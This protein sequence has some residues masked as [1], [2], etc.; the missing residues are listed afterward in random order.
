MRK[1]SDFTAVRKNPYAAEIDDFVTIRQARFGDSLAIFEAHRD[2]VA[3][4]CANS[5]TAAQLETWFEGR[6][7]E[8]HLP[9]IHAGQVFIA[10]R[11]GQVL[12]FFGFVP[13]EVTLLF[14]R[15][16]ASGAGLGSRLLALA[17]EHAAAGHTGSLAVVATKNSQRFYEK[18][19][20][21]A[22]GE[23]SF[24]RGAA[25]LHYQVISMQRAAKVEPAAVQP[26]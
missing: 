4:L 2:S 26:D 9:A 7:H 12:G 8:I 14:V 16:Q 25:Q 5:Y 15:P 21:A 6:T 23:S 1:E 3:G 19:G 17:L 11:A 20:F 22:V 24:V 10:E 18:H 13:G